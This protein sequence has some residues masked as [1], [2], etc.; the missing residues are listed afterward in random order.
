MIIIFIEQHIGLET[1]GIVKW[2][3]VNYKYIN[4]LKKKFE[5][6]HQAVLITAEIT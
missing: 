5:N 6:K 3:M 2:I 4:K 1:S